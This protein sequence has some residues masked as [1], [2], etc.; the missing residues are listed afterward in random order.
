[1]GT[2]GKA[3]STATVDGGE[4]VVSEVTLTLHAGE[5]VRK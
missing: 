2:A 1:M 5:C 4:A 3:E